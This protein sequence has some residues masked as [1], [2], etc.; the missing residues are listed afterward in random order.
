MKDSNRDFYTSLESGFRDGSLQWNSY[1]VNL[2]FLDFSIDF[3]REFRYLIDLREVYNNLRSQGN[4]WILR[5]NK[6]R[7]EEFFRDGDYD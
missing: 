4:L 7:F 1:Y 6:R 5:Q 2:H 3:C